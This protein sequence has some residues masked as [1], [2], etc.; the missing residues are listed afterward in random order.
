MRLY[1]PWPELASL[2]SLQIQSCRHA[3]RVLDIADI[4]QHDWHAGQLLVHRARNGD[5]HV[6]LIDLASSTQTVDP[7]NFNELCNFDGAFRTL[8]GTFG[9]SGLDLQLVLDHFGRPDPWDPVTVGINVPVGPPEA[10][11]HKL[12]TFAAPDPFGL[13]PE[14]PSHL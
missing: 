7:D 8:A 14:I 13:K 6:V 4:A 5:V 3:A 12:Y 10:K 9:G 2:Q 1:L 11:Q